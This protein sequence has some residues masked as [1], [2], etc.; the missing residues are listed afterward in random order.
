[1]PKNW[2]EFSLG[3]A[4]S[5]ISDECSEIEDISVRVFSLRGGRIPRDK[6]REFGR[7]LP[8]YVECANPRCSRGRF[9]VWPVIRMAASRHDED[10]RE[11]KRVQ[12][13]GRPR[14]SMSLYVRSR[15]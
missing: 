14:S 4:M 10:I 13:L 5:T 11:A 7:D 2:V 6:P 1:M 8:E 12:W 9:R 3:L 15:G